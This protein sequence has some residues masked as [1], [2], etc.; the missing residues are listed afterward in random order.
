MAL[1]VVSDKRYVNRTRAMVSINPKLKRIVMNKT[2]RELMIEHHKDEFEHVLLMIDPEVPNCFWVRACNANVEG[3]RQLNQ[4]SGSTRT[5]SCSLLLNELNWTG[6]K[7]ESYPLVWDPKNNAAKVDLSQ[8][9]K[10]DAK[11]M[12]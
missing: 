2:A 1:V 6:N 12:K 3:A 11:I 9:Q 5:V 4:T 7:T 8:S 10:G